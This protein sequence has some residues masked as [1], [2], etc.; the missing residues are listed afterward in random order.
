[1]LVDAVL[2]AAGRFSN[3]AA[4]NLAGRRP[5]ARAQRTPVR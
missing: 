4:L 3:T 1:M 2:V 5:D